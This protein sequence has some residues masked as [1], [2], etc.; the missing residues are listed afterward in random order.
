[1]ACTTQ[2]VRGAVSPLSLSLTEAFC[3]DVIIYAESADN[4]NLPN[5]VFAVACLERC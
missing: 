2:E 3:K 1:M 4:S 5:A